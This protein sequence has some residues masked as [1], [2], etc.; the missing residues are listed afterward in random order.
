M[1]LKT[2]TALQMPDLPAPQVWPAP[3]GQRGSGYF[4]A[5]CSEPWALRMV[6]SRTSVGTA[7]GS[8][9]FPHVQKRRLGRTE[10]ADRHTASLGPVGLTR[11]RGRTFRRPW[12]PVT[13]LPGWGLLSWSPAPP[14]LQTPDVRSPLREG[15]RIRL[16]ALLQENRVWEDSLIR[17]H[18][19]DPWVRLV[20]GGDSCRWDSS[21]HMLGRRLVGAL[22]PSGP[23]Q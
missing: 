5:Q 6:C 21:G 20:H 13:R 23:S 7:R 2:L 12:A 16:T 9:L 19:T 10:G 3:L 15:Q 14:S 8:P 18:L 17:F 4:Y 1:T 11:R 22:T